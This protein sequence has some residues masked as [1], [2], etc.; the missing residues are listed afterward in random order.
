MPIEKHVWDFTNLCRYVISLTTTTSNNNNNK[1][2]FTD[3]YENVLNEFTKKKFYCYNY[4]K[5]NTADQI[6]NK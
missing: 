6:A 4:T 2:D 3:K 5:N 1:K